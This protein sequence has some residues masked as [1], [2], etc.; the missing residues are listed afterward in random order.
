MNRMETWLSGIIAQTAS[1]VCSSIFIDEQLTKQINNSGV[2]LS[3]HACK[4]SF[5]YAKHWF[6]YFLFCFPDKASIELAYIH[7]R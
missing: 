6:N 2:K 4:N 3:Q 5:G 7:I 1:A